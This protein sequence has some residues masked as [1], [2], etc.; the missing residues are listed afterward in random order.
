MRPFCPECLMLDIQKNHYGTW[1]ITVTSLH[2]EQWIL[3]CCIDLLNNQGL[4][5]QGRV[6]TKKEQSKCF[7]VLTTKR[8]KSKFKH[9]DC[10]KMVQSVMKA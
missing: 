3:H 2:N 4:A 9:F 10:L 6:Q 7:T 8:Q 1:E 5:E